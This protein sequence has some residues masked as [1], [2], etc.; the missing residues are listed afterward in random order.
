MNEYGILSEI[1]AKASQDYTNW[2]IGITDH[3]FGRR[4]EHIATGKKVERRAH[5]DVGS[6]AN[7]RKIELHFLSRGMKDSTDGDT[8]GKYVYIF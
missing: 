8:R 1:K 2:V 3:P 7:A 6:E 4:V 5:W